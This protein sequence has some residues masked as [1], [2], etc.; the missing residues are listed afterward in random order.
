MLAGAVLVPAALGWIGG[1]LEAG[2][3]FSFVSWVDSVRSVELMERALRASDAQRAVQV[4]VELGAVGGRTG[5]RDLAAARSVAEAVLRTSTLRLV[6]V[7]G[8]EGA[9]AHDSSDV[10]MRTVDAYPRCLADVHATL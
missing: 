8:Y 3:G 5:A 2:P 6:G 1:Q 4:C 10:A 9:L 7:A